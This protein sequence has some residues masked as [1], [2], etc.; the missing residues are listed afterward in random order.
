MTSAKST[1]PPA[2]NVVKTEAEWQQKLSAAEYHVMRKAG[3]ERAGSGP[4]LDEHRDGIFLCVSCDAHLFETNAKYESGTGWPSFFKPITENA[5]SEHEDR[6]L[7]SRRTEIRCA[8]CDG[9]LGHVF[10]DGPK[11]TGLRYCMNGVALKFTP[12]SDADD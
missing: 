2:P 9:H 11:P 8:N 1:T 4:H 6:G 12:G 5:V 3:T 10:P 7:F